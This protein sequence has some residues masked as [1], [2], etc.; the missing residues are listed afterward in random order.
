MNANI[1]PIYYAGTVL[2]PGLIIT[3]QFDVTFSVIYHDLTAFDSNIM[4]VFAL[5]REKSGIF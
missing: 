1:S 2:E 4:S 3:V 5:S